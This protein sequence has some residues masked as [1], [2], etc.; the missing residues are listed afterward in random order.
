M[1]LNACLRMAGENRGEIKGS[2]NLKGWEGSI[3]VLAAEHGVVSALNEVGVPGGTRRHRPFVITKDVD[4]SS[5]LLYAMLAEREAIVQ[6]SLHTWRDTVVGRVMQRYTVELENAQIAG[7][8]F[9]IFP[10]ETPEG[11]R[12]AAHERVSFC[13]ERIAWTWEETGVTFTDD[14]EAPTV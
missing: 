5:P 13:Y 10:G 3:A 8:E 12:G 14:W 11:E 2:V 4:A 7:I 6:W 9:E 1:A